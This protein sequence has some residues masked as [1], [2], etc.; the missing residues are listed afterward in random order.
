MKKILL[1][2][3]TLL[4]IQGQAQNKYYITKV[5]EYV[6]APG[7]FVNVLPAYTS[8]DNAATMCAKCL[9]YFNQDYTVSLGAFGGYITVGFDHTI[10]NKE[11][12][13]D[14]KV[15]GN[16]FDGSAEPGI[17]LVSADTNKDGLPNDTWYELKGSEYDNPN[18]IHNYQITYYK[19][20]NATDKVRWTD[21]KTGEGYVLRNTFH[22]QAYYPQ[23]INAETMTYQGSR[24]QNNGTF[25]SNLNKWVMASYEYGYADNQPN[26]S[27][28]CKLKLDWAVDAN[29]NSVKVK[30]V[31]FI[32]IYTA[33]NQAIENGVGEISTEISGVEDLH[34]EL[35]GESVI[36]T[37]INQVSNNS[38]AIY[39][40][41]R[42][43]I[44]EEYPCI[45]QAYNL[46]GTVVG[47]WN[48]EGGMQSFEFTPARGV[49]LIKTATNNQKIV[50]T[51]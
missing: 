34:P 46:Q 7:Q 6:P 41:G 26:I 32:R 44:E 5:L 37:A 27:D 49:Y 39:Q 30:G 8:G 48:H 3:I 20:A 23:W 36:L 1:S 9:D 11:G 38:K 10:A 4:A 43:T 16:A 51:R 14:I 47:Q 18:T 19:P 24:L 15:L 40:D 2:I 42:L 35:T 33:V 31:D 25:D 29:G 17:V 21:N 45:V 50:V 28:G 13:Y 12:E 22:T